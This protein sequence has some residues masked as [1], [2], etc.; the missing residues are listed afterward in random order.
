MKKLRNLG[1]L[2]AEQAFR[3]A[4]GLF[5]MTLV[6]RHLGPERFGAFTYLF[7][8]AGLLLPLAM[9]G[10]EGIL[11]RRAAAE[12]AR[13]HGVLATGMALRFGG[14]A[15]AAAL[16]V[17][18]AYLLPPPGGAAPA[19]AF[20]AIVFLLARPGESLAIMFKAEE[21]MAWV[22][23]PRMVVVTLIA[24]ATLYL[25]WRGAGLEAFVA[26]RAAEALALALAAFAAYGWASGG[27]ARLRPVAAE[28]G[29][30]A[31]QAWPLLLGGA[32]GM[33]YLRVDQVMLGQLSTAGELG[34]YGVA[35]RV[36]EVANF[37]PM[38]LQTVFYASLVRAHQ[39]APEMFEREMQ[40]LY[41]ALAL[42]GYAAAAGVAA[43]SWLL[44]TPVFGAAY[45][46]GVDSLYILLLGAPFHFLTHGWLAMLAI[47]GWL[48]T[49]TAAAGAAA[50]VNIGLNFLLIPAFGAPG[51]AAA[52]V[53]AY[54]MAA[55]GAAWTVP[56][57]RPG[58]RSMARALNPVGAAIR[59]ARVW[60]GGRSGA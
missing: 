47:R 37:A 59:L 30:L 12:P 51:A 11:M 27:F 23:I 17:A 35:A 31:R 56:R 25:V 43:A 24:A 15:L 50:V 4:F 21:R 44:F 26:L 38:A 42:A 46:G 41:D 16:T 2:T 10:L 49:T 28:F 53:A 40:P 6:A 5:V 60:R 58:A 3:M 22:A 19:L 36:S 39:R 57:L 9:L 20:L 55:F 14:A 32:A 18:A 45:A 48:W 13:M 54:A 34:L 1:W 29:P 33:V 7:G 8:L 52:T